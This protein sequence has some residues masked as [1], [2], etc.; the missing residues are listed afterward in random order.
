M[1]LALPHSEGG[2]GARA[3]YRGGS[4]GASAC[5]S[6]MRRIRASWR[7]TVRRAQ[8]ELHRDLVARLA[9]HSQHRQPSATR[10]HPD[11]QATD[12][13]PRRPWRRNRALARSRRLGPGYRRHC[14]RRRRDLGRGRRSVASRTMAVPALLASWRRACAMTFRVVVTT[15]RLQ[16]SSRSASWGNWPRANPAHRLSKALRAAS[17][18]SLPAS[19]PATCAAAIAPA[20]PS[21]RS[22]APRARCAAQG[23]PL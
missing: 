23:R 11:V 6:R 22:T 7:A 21:G 5:V 15:S 18:S 13:T 12:S 1:L 14:R 20:P 17:S 10:R 9:L 4:G 2:A 3:S 8:P 19:G 16:R